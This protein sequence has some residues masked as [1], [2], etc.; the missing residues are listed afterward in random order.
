MIIA[1]LVVQGVLNAAA[2]ISPSKAPCFLTM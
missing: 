2:T 1:R